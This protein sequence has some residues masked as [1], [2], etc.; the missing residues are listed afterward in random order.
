MNLEKADCRGIKIKESKLDQAVF[1]QTQLKN[2]KIEASNLSGAILVD[3]DLEGV[4]I[5]KVDLSHADLKGA[6]LRDARVEMSSFRGAIFDEKTILPFKKKTALSRGMI[7]V[8]C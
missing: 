2:A 1:S 4:E 6:N 5:F 3:A 8:S 7:Y